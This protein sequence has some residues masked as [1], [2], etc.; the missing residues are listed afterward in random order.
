MEKKDLKKC[1]DKVFAC[2]FIHTTTMFEYIFSLV[3]YYSDDD[4]SPE[5]QEAFNRLTGML[6]HIE[7]M[8]DIGSTKAYRVPSDFRCTIE[9]YKQPIPD[10]FTFS[11]VINLPEQHTISIPKNQI[12]EI[13]EQIKDINIAALVSH[14]KKKAIAAGDFVLE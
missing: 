4:L 6:T 7:L 5:L 14:I 11:P 10:H 13:A 12:D 9:T 3:S 2:D 8:K 1:L